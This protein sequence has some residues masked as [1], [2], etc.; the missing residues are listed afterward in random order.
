MSWRIARSNGRIELAGELRMADGAAIWRELRRA[1]EKPGPRLDVDLADAA[2]VD[3]AIMALL[4][5][6]RAELVARGVRS[7]LVGAGER[8][9]RIVHLY[10][11][12]VAAEPVHEEAREPPI[13]RLGAASARQLARGRK[14]VEFTGDLLA[15]AGAVVRRPATLSWRSLPSL[16]AQTGT[17]GLPIV[18]MLN[19]LVGFVI[20]FQSAEELRIF[21]ANVYVADLVG[22][23][24]T[25]ELGPLMTAIIVAGRS[26]AAF[27]AELGTMRV[28]EEIDAL[29]T[30]GFQPLPY[31]VLPRVLALAIVAPLLTLV[32]DVVGVFGGATVAAR[33]LDI[34]PDGYLSELRTIVV[35]ADVW[36]GLVK[37]LAFGLAIALIGC[38]QGLQTRGAA[39]A[40]GRSTTATVVHC[41]FAIV[42]IDTL[43][44]MLFRRLGV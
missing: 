11:G 37:S 43:F 7:E 32:G 29:R 3:G 14:L 1:C 38:R 31:L 27:A 42:V 23:S 10:G 33:S 26:G 16:V 13:A 24:M 12:D 18:T 9:R 35:S 21:G 25:R 30:M 22:V 5:D 8:L 20:A 41:L 36:T 19:F 40:V 4:V 39:A 15:A 17:D 6:V 2:V 44:T 28:S 34:T